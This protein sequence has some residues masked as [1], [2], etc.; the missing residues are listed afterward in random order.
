MVTGA[1]VADLWHMISVLLPEVDAVPVWLEVGLEEEV[2]SIWDTCPLKKRVSVLL[3]VPSAFV[4]LTTNVLRPF[5]KLPLNE[6]FALPKLNWVIAV[7]FKVTWIWFCVTLVAENEKLYGVLLAPGF[8]VGL[9]I[10]TTGGLGKAFGLYVTIAVL[11]SLPSGLVAVIS[12]L[13]APVFNMSVY[14]KFNPS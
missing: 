14:P 7:P 5:T 12:K 10:V 4:A 3:S 6:P 2:V 8:P 13:L 9:I 1:S 11:T